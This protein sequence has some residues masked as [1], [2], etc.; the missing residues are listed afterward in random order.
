MCPVHSC[1]FTADRGWLR[2]CRQSSS[3]SPSWVST[4]PGFEKE[5]TKWMVLPQSRTFHPVEC[6][7]SVTTFFH[8][9]R[10]QMLNQRN[11]CPCAYGSPGCVGWRAGTVVTG[12][13][14]ESLLCLTVTQRPFKVI[15]TWCNVRQ[16][17]RGSGRPP[18]STGSCTRLSP[19]AVKWQ[20]RVWGPARGS[21]G[22]YFLC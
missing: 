1:E 10:L 21:D 7:S 8:T 18:T 2:C 14:N 11:S 15:L 20:P 6:D 17:L 3:P 19:P 9:L 16:P 22:S 12:E 5:R 4:P 13:G